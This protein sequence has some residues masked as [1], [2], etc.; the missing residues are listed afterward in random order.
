LGEF[1]ATKK[2]GEPEKNPKGF[3]PLANREQ[4]GYSKGVP[5]PLFPMIYDGVA[6]SFSLV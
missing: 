6:S 4:R 1:P 3:F 5:T 2:G